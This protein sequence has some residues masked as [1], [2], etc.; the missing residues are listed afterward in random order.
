MT[1]L[2]YTLLTDPAPLEASRARVQRTSRNDGSI[3]FP[4]AGIQVCNGLYDTPRGGCVFA[5]YGIYQNQYFSRED[6]NRWIDLSDDGE[7]SVK[8]RHK[9]DGTTT[10]ASLKVSRLDTDTHRW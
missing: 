8:H 7:V 2:T 6:D 3:T 1:L 5:E 9:G 4:E 10:Y